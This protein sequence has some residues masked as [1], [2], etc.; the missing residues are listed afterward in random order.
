MTSVNGV[1]SPPSHFDSAI[2]SLPLSAKRKREDSNEA[3]NNVNGIANASSGT[4]AEETKAS[5]V[6]LIDIL[7][8]YVTV[9]P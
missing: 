8:V 7:K 4:T 1:L 2:P 5:I 3:S 9:F 6:D